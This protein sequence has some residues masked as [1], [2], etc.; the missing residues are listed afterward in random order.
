MFFGERWNCD[1]FK[2]S[3]NSRVL[4]NYLKCNSGYVIGTSTGWGGKVIKMVALKVLGEVRI[5]TDGCFCDTESPAPGS[6][7][8]ICLAFD[9]E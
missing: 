4:E 8:V 5:Q 2:E 3:K 9:L 6:V 1:N 7:P